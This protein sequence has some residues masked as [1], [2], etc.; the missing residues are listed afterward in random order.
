MSVLRGDQ[1]GEIERKPVRVVQSERVVTR[2]D[3]LVTELL[4][5][6]EPAFD[7]LE[8]P[9]LLGARHALDVLLFR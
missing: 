4:H 9:L 6:R 7:R 2:D 8:E 3:R 5:S 1:L